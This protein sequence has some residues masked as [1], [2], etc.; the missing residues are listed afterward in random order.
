MF[1]FLYITDRSKQP[2]FHL[3]YESGTNLNDFCLD[4]IFA[5]LN[6]KSVQLQKISRTTTKKKHSWDHSA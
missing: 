6:D 4:L 2:Q 5:H 1:L 3:I